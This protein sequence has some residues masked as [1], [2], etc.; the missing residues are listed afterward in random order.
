MEADAGGKNAGNAT[1]YELL[2]VDELGQGWKDDDV[3]LPHGTGSA[4]A[5]KC[6]AAVSVSGRL[7]GSEARDTN[8]AECA[9]CCGSGECA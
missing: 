8:H 6:V 1:E 7:G 2:R 3:E 9:E 5:F 4:G